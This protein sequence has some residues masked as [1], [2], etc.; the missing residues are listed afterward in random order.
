MWRTRKRKPG[1]L[2]AVVLHWT[3]AENPAS[4]MR[5][6][7]ETRNLSVHAFVD[8]KGQVTHFEDPAR[9]VCLHAG[10]AN[11]WSAGV[12]IANVGVGALKPK[13]P[14]TRYPLALNGRPAVPCAAFYPEQ[15]TSVAEL[16]EGWCEAY[17]IPRELPREPDGGVA[18]RVL[19]AEEQASFSGVLGHFH[20]AIG[21]RDPGKDLLQYLALRW[22][23][24]T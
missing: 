17:G 12:E 24:R 8:Q 2:R 7:L 9:V 13:W 5:R 21:K 15:L 16:V 22:G 11:E 23:Q 10:V 14:R 1:T 18:W 3:G 20:V 19:S 6:T 4:T